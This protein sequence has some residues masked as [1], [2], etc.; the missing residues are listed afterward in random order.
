MNGFGFTRTLFRANI[1]IVPFLFVQNR[2]FEVLQVV[3][4]VATLLQWSW[5]I[6]RYLWLIYPRHYITISI[7]IGQVLSKLW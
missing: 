4:C 7:K 3:W 5:K 6:L 2:Y 1:H